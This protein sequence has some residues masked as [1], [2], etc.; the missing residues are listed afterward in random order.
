[1]SV[2]DMLRLCCQLFLRACAILFYRELIPDVVLRAG[3]R[4]LVAWDH[5]TGKYRSSIQQLPGNLGINDASQSWWQ[6]DAE[7][8]SNGLSKYLNTKHP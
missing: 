8:Y 1:M 2:R 4:M 3:L 5:A 6:L 7:V